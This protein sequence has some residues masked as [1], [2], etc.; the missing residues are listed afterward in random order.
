MNTDFKK[1][2]WFVSVYY[3]YYYSDLKF[4]KEHITTCLELKT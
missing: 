3:I 1:P 2:A 4:G